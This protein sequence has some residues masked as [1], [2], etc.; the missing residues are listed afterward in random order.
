MKLLRVICLLLV[1]VVSRPAIGQDLHFSQI[2]SS[3]TMLNP[4]YTGFMNGNLRFGANYRNQW[5]TVSSFSTYAVSADMNIIRD[6]LDMDMLGVGLSFFQDVEEKEGF[7]NTNISLNVAYNVK[8]SNRP[9]QYLGF[10]L[11]PSFV[12]KQINLMDAVYGTFY[13]TGINTDPLG[14]SEYNQFKFDLNMG[15]SYYIYFDRRHIFNVG[16]NMSHINRPDFGIYAEDRLY[17][18]YTAYVLTEFEAGQTGTAWMKPIVYF[19]KQ[20]PSTEILGGLGV[21]F[22]FFNAINDVYLGFNG[23]V[24]FVGHSES[25]IKS[26]DFVGSTQLTIHMFTVGFSYDVA[27]GEIN[28]ASGRNGG[29]EVSLIV[30]LKTERRMRPSYFKMIAF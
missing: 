26:T 14:F 6:N 18:K 22:K 1:M 15:L 25:N 19:S 30:D 24:R 5:F 28:T 11:Q 13:E 29:P 8:L 27:I 7:K 23:S 17:H 9:L 3:P 10:G 2:S 4:A 16:F 21:R 12:R 20:G